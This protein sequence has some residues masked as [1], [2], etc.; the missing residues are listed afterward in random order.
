MPPR[1]PAPRRASALLVSLLLLLT[2]AALA[3]C[4]PA[5]A[6]PAGADPAPSPGSTSAATPRL[7]TGFNASERDF[8]AVRRVLETRAQA[9][10]DG[11][12]TAFLATVDDADPAFVARQRAVFE[13]LRDLHVTDLYYGV[14]SVGFPP[15]RVRGRGPTLRPDVIEHVLVPGSDYQPVANRVQ[16]TFVRRQGRWL[17]GAETFARKQGD[18]AD[19]QSRPWGQ[20][21]IAVATRG[22]L[23][24]VVDADR[25]GRLDA[26]ADAVEQGIHE[27]S[28]LLG[29]PY[30][31][32]LLVDATSSGTV[33]L[34]NEVDGDGAGAE[35]AATTFPAFAATRVS[36]ENA[37]LAGWRIKM[38]PRKLDTLL[39]DR[40]V[41]RHE[42]T[43]YVLRESTVPLWLG[44]GIA[45][46][47]GWQPLG[48]DDL[49]LSPAVYDRIVGSASR[50]ELP[51]SGVFSTF[52]DVNYV[53]AFAAVTELASRGGVA[54]VVRLIDSYA[55]H[56]GPDRGDSWTPRGL[57]RVFGITEA[58][59]ASATYDRLLA[60]QH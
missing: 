16:L 23:T 18:F 44:E 15:A 48:L 5:A 51:G 24:V 27:V 33:D 57:R 43:H 13:N 56:T 17:L 38:N 47:A 10:I 46:Y 11:D 9:V 36:Y 40:Q 45:E 14:A 25:A 39:G 1:R 31:A 22:D 54:E 21:R 26:L 2:P 19:T 20:G 7:R 50:T 8:T 32:A 34:V 3:G 59:L 60:L 6:P 35:A 42:L 41:L 29:R 49:T 12:E 37:G 28:T 58:E 4:S 55:G 30:Q 53:V 52:P